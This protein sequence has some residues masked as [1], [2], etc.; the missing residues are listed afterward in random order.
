MKERSR[1]RTDRILSD[2]SEGKTTRKKAAALLKVSERTVSR[3]CK[4]RQENPD[5]YLVHGNA[6]HR[7]E[8]RTPK[9]TAELILRLYREKYDGFGFSHFRDMLEEYEGLSV[10]LSTARAVLVAGGIESPY[11]HRRRKKEEHPLR[12]RRPRFGEMVQVDATFGAFFSFAGDYEVYAIHGIVD[13]ATG[14][15]LALW[16]DRQETLE[17]YRRVLSKMLLKYGICEEWYTDG[18]T[19]FCGGFDNDGMPKGSPAGTQFARWCIDLGITLLCTSVPQAKGR[20]ERLWGTFKRRWVREFAL[21]GITRM[22]QFNE[23]SEEL[24]AKHNAM[25]A[26]RPRI[27]ESRFVPVGMSERELELL[28]SIRQTRTV[29]NGCFVHYDK[30]RIQLIKDDGTVLELG[31]KTEIEVRLTCRGEIYGYYD[32]KYYRT[33]VIGEGE[34]AVSSSLP[35]PTKEKNETKEGKKKHK[36][37]ENHPW[38][39][40]K[41]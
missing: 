20:I 41:I 23:R 19:V 8:K 15:V 31:S 11:S 27:D 14:M 28:L 39:H 18:R 36:P 24:A 6:G 26:V 10:P 21:M 17:G 35:L 5:G 9:E 38:R 34:P 40:M 29:A 37:S 25:F 30:K 3:M 12:A 4:R 32:R 7:S 2:F 13:D 33:K 1:N 22:D 16:M